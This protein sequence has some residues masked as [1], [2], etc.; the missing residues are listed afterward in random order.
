[1][2]AV[3]RV[4]ERTGFIDDTV[5]GFLGFNHDTLDLIDT[6]DDLRMQGNGG[7]NCCLG[8]ELGWKGNLEQ[9]IFHRVGA[10]ALGE[11]E[12]FLAKRDILKS[13]G[14]CGDRRGIAHL[15]P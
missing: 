12:R 5:T 3:R 2:I 10:V 1:M 7:F 13:P 6:I 15:T 11:L 8:V 14:G 9:N 4:V